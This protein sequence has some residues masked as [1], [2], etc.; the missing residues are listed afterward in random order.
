MVKPFCYSRGNSN[1]EWESWRAIVTSSVK[2]RA[3]M[4]NEQ[5][6]ATVVGPHRLRTG[7]EKRNSA[8]GR[9]IVGY[10]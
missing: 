8:G 6:Y 9:Q 10:T 5:S 3:K 7:A 1:G 4:T 2:K